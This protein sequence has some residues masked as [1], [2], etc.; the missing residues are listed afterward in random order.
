MQ[1]CA[2]RRVESILGA[3]NNNNNN[4]NKANP[5]PYKAASEVKEMYL[6]SA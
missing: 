3:A 5:P 6:H 4:S 1:S 2:Q